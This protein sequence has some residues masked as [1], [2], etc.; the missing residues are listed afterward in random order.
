MTRAELA[1]ERTLAALDFASIVA[2]VVAATA[3]Q[4]G[5]E[6][7]RSLRPHA[8]FALVHVE[9]ARTAAIRERIGQ[10]DLRVMAADE[11]AE[12]L[13]AAAVGSTLTGGSLRTV[14]DAIAAAA[15]AHNALNAQR[16]VA[17]SAV[18]AAYT[19]LKELHT[20]LTDAIDER[21][22]VLDR[23]SPQLERIRRAY[24]QAQSDA[25]D[26]VTATLHSPR[27]A[28]AI[29]DSVVTLREG[30]FVVPI[31]AEFAGE[32]PG[33]VHDT[34]S[35]GQTLFV[36]PLSAVDANNRVRTLRVEEE[37]EV[38]RVLGNLSQ[39]VGA[40]A[41][42]IDANVE[43]L[44]TIDIIVAKA[45]VAQ[46]MNAIPPELDAGAL[47][48]VERGRHPLLNER[49]VAQTVVLD[50]ATRI[51]VI[52]GP[53]MGGKTVA[54]KTVGLFIAMAY[55]GLQLPAS[56]GTTIG[57]FD[58][59]I[60]DIG[61]E[62]SILG[63]VS[64]FSAHLERLREMLAL[65]GPKTLVLVDEIGGGTE[66]GAGAALAVAILERMIASGACGVV[67]T[68]DTELKLFASATPGVRNASVRF[69]P[70]TF[71]PSFQ[72][73]VGAPG[74]SLAF[75][76]AAALGIDATI[77]ER[78]QALLDSRERD[79]E[80]ALAELSLRSAQLTHER[81]ALSRER[82][83]VAKDAAE[84]AGERSR[85][86]ATRRE[87]ASHADERMQRALRDFVA[88]LERRAKAASSTRARVTS[89]QS[90][91][92]TRTGEAM[93]RD[94]GINPEQPAESAAGNLE[95]NERVHILS[96]GQS[97]S[98]LED[99]GATV[100]VA[101]GAMKTVVPKSDLQRTTRAE[102]RSGFRGQ[103]AIRSPRMDATMRSRA[104]LDVRGQRYV[105]AQP[106]VEKWVDDA[107][108]AGAPRLRLI[109]GKGTG[110]LGRGL[111]EYLRTHP[112]V[113]SVRY[114]SED[115]GSAG[116]TIVEIAVFQR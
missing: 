7:A 33:I 88:E 81:D 112:S 18:L 66:P 67:T 100:L 80:A 114:A 74:Q 41:D 69:D 37:R 87:F 102:D 98:V 116:V 4:R 17:F 55:S 90:E 103:A 8:D 57:C 53:N 105:D 10:S 12:L 54:L 52:S 63:N 13:Q 21:G 83:Q 64:T 35:S 106:L 38:A 49:A 84:L 60:A 62:Q 36:E 51:L 24:G 94:L 31:K 73:D 85:F 56:P 70:A 6:R 26:R 14:A 68:H 111:Q 79:Y 89:A 50:E 23:A 99:Y 19:S 101:F 39:Q 75:P 46:V 92:L 104:E 65:S 48:R 42:R 115:E 22:V 11:P 47:V 77:I 44:A 107:V 72:L 25:R 16:H 45:I 34:S 108:A 20:A 40:Q 9:Q 59:I 78:A 27:Y 86:D 109:H 96:L 28:K 32:F 3:T 5:R 110:M 2:R 29:Q 76:L 30:R 71:R 113:E 82:M 97:G 43:M 61:D 1:D 93:R 91:L 95:P 15:A 58:H